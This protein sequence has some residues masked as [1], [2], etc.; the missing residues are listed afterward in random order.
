MAHDGSVTEIPAPANGERPGVSEPTT[1]PYCYKHPRAAV[2][3]DLVV[4]ALEGDEL[5]VLLIRRKHPPFEGSW[6][7]PGGFLEID[8]EIEAAARRELR[9]ETGFEATGPVTLFR[10]FGKPGRDPRG[11]TI[12]LAHATAVRGPNRS[13]AGGDDASE[14]GWLDPREARHLAFD[15]DEI[16][17]DA[18]DWLGRAIEEGPIGLG[19]L[20]DE[21]DDVDVKRL[22]RAV[23]K[24]PRSARSWRTALERRGLVRPVDGAGGRY[25][26]TS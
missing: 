24:P 26:S 1:L 6:A 23:G 18:L 20:P 4:F 5:R 13:V 19:M 11:R 12:S 22:F 8:E 3:V 9:E 2:T 17:A 14:A 25:R 21:F 16:L 15:H 10:V 7:I